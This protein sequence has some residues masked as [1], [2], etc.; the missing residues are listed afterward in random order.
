VIY[1]YYKG[2]QA[3]KQGRHKEGNRGDLCQ[4]KD[5]AAHHRKAGRNVLLDQLLQPERVM[6][7]L[8]ALKARRDQPQACADRRIVDLARQASEA[9]ER[10]TPAVRKSVQGWCP[11]AG[12]PSAYLTEAKSIT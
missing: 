9:E 6:S 3:I 5:P 1:A 4:P 11:G 2:V 8:L 7:I 12:C 10:R